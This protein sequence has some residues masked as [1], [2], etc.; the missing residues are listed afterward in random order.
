MKRFENILYV[1]EEDAEDDPGA[2]ARAV[3]LADSN[4]ARL[5]VLCTAEHPRL[6]PFAGKL[7][8]ADYEA[9]VRAQAA[10]RLEAL[11]T[12]FSESVAVHINVVFGAP[13]VQVIRDVLRNKR[14]L[15]VKA[16]GDGGMHRFLYGGIDQHLLRKCPC[17]VWIV[18][19]QGPGQYKRVLAAIDFD[20][21]DEDGQ[22]EIVNRRIL[23][24]AGAIAVADFAELH[25][26]HAWESVTENV[27]RVFGSELSQ[28]D[29]AENIERERRNHLAR[30]EHLTE[31]LR[32]WIGADSY[33]YLSPRLHLRRGSARN[34]IP[35]LA[36]ELQ[37]DLVVM[38]TISRTGI[39]GL[40][41]GNTA[42]VILNNI[43]CAVLAVKPPGFVSPVQL[44]DT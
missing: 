35:E 27:L 29:A 11:L 4:Q 15:V 38:G 33:D 23:E 22:E 25:V 14:D 12:P 17:P 24:M 31:S 44:S 30:M 18:Q 41:I 42:E 43:A 19:A 9:R 20:P 5:T 26:A 32:R 7:E 40:I 2:L 28:Y 8:L 16:A 37:T 36:A 13:V 10:A 21:W 3:A 34:V 39:P 6:G 1:V